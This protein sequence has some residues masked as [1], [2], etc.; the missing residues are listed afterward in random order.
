MPRDTRVPVV[1]PMADTSPDDIGR[2]FGFPL[3]VKARVGSSGDLISIVG[4]LEELRSVVGAWGAPPECCLY[5]QYVDGTKLNYAAAVGISGGIEQEL[6]YR[7]SQWRYPAGAATEIET[8]DD[9]QLA[10]FGRN[11][12]D[13]VDCTGLI[14]IDVI[15]D[16]QGVDWL[17]D[18]NARAFGGSVC[19][20]GAGLDISE[21]YL[22][23][24]GQRQ[25]PPVRRM[26]LDGIPIRLFPECLWDVIDSGSVA[27]HDGSIL[28][29]VLALPRMARR[30]LLGG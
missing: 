26:P 5:E 11:A 29:R 3:V 16:P 7:I 21:G 18:F 9:P 10:T 13:V 27:A 30:P 25:L 28:A 15:R 23:A 4:D 20:L 6:T 14:N 1:I 12:V 22:V 8:V 19:F 17:I 24:I 2:K